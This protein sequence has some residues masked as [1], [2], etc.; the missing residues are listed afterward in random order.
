[1]KLIME[2]FRSYIKETGED[3]LAG[4]PVPDLFGVWNADEVEDW[5]GDKIL[6]DEDDLPV[7]VLETWQLSLEK[8][9]DIWIKDVIERNRINLKDLGDYE[10]NELY[11]N[12]KKG[13][14]KYFKA[15]T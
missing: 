4:A 12:I 1:M 14:E 9:P 5:L 13:I 2:N 6:M 10:K 3:Q 11:F 7:N 15:T 8:N